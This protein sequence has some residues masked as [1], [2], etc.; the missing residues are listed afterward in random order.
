M[1]PSGTLC[2]TITGANVGRVG[3]LEFDA[4]FPDSVVGLTAK[5]RDTAEYLRVWFNLLLDVLKQ[6]ATESTQP[7]I[8]LAILRSLSVPLPP[9]KL[10]TSFAR[11]VQA[12]EAL[13]RS[14]KRAITATE[15]LFATLQHRAFRGE[16]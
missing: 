1:W 15:I 5:N 13:R 6:R 8:N 7:N 10:L 12:A 9:Q 16:L 3:I 14:A 11:R 2:I 4:C